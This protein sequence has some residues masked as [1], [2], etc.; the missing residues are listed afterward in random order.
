MVPELRDI[1]RGRI[2]LYQSPARLHFRYGSNLV[3]QDDILEEGFAAGGSGSLVALR[4]VSDAASNNTPVKGV[5]AVL[6]C[7][8]N[9]PGQ[10]LPRQDFA[11]LLS[12]SCR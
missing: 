1:R 5:A 10:D 7:F 3:K 2:I 12:S 11:A 9:F 6:S 4:K 8:F